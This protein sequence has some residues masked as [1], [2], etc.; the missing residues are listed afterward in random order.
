MYSSDAGNFKDI[1][2]YQLILCKQMV[3]A[4]ARIQCFWCHFGFAKALLL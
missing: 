4:V 1:F 3:G 2:I